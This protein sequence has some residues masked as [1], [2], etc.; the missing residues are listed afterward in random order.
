MKHATK[1]NTHNIN[2]MKDK[3]KKQKKKNNW[4]PSTGRT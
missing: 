1:K 3:A 2:E 4:T